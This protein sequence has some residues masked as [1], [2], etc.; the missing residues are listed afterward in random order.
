M[1][2]AGCRTKA[3][4]VQRALSLFDEA[5]A[6]RTRLN[7]TRMI[8]TNV[9]DADIDAFVELTREQ[10]AK[11]RREFVEFVTSALDEGAVTVSTR[12]CRR[13][14]PRRYQSNE[15]RGGS[16]SGRRSGGA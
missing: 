10:V 7:L 4:A 2:L 3:D 5:I 15:R 14:L 13:Q 1:S 11:S 8:A 16:A 12:K 6:D 9:D